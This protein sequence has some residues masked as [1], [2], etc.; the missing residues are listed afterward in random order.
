MEEEFESEDFDEEVEE[1]L[2]EETLAEA[3]ADL[4]ADI[5]DEAIDDVVVEEEEEVVLLEE[6]EP[7]SDEVEASL[8]QILEERVGVKAGIDDDDDED[9]D[10]ADP[11]E[12]RAAG[13]GVAPKRPGEFTCRSCFLVKH[14]SQLADAERVLCR[15]CV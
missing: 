7:D 12:D 14:P 9:F 3:D 4:E 13:T 8:D 5:D 10:D 2:D 11:A 1:E 15:D 6:D